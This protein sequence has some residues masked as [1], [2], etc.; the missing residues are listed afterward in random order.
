MNNLFYLFAEKQAGQNRLISIHEYQLDRVID[1]ND[2]TI[3]IGPLTL[4]DLR[5]DNKLQEYMSTKAKRFY[6]KYDNNDGDVKG[7]VKLE[8]LVWSW[9]TNWYDKTSEFKGFALLI[10]L[11]MIII[12]HLYNV[13][14]LL[15]SVTL[16]C[17][18]NLRKRRWKLR[19][20]CKVSRRM[21][22]SNRI[23]KNLRNVSEP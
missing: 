6:I 21:L 19:K 12:H 22:L 11:S 2:R 9:L 3:F 1:I 23:M 15:L 14:L 18:S 4:D 8:L 20:I 10:F 7:Y 5:T 13:P 17:F 16:N